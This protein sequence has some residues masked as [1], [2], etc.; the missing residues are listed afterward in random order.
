MY[1]FIDLDTGL[2]AALNKI[3]TWVNSK[4]ASKQDAIND[5]AT[6]RSG[7]ALGATAIQSHQ[8]IKTLNGTSLVGTGNVN[9]PAGVTPHIDE[10]TGNWFI[11]TNDTGIHAQGPKGDTGDV[12]ITDG[13]LDNLNIVNNLEGASG[14]LDSRQGKVIKDLLD[15]FEERLDTIDGASAVSVNATSLVITPLASIDP[16]L[17]VTATDRNILPSLAGGTT[18]TKF[19][20]LGRRLNGDISISAS[21]TTNFSLSQATIP[22]FNGKVNATEITV[23]YHPASGSATNTQHACTITVST[24]GATNVQMSLTGQVVTLSNIVLTPATLQLMSAE[25][26][27]QSSGTIHVAGTAL[28]GDVTLT[29]SDATHLSFSSTATISTIVVTK[30]QAEAGAGYDVL[31]YYDGAATP[32]SATVT[33]TS[34]GADSK[35]VSIAAKVP[36]AK[37][38]GTTFV[39]S[40]LHL[41]FTVLAD[42]ST[43]SVAGSSIPAGTDI[44]IPSTISDL[45]KTCTL[46]DADSEGEGYTYNV[47]KVYGYTGSGSMARGTFTNA[48]SVVIPNSVTSIGQYSFRQNSSIQ[49]LTMST[50]VT[51]IESATFAL[52]TGMTTIT[53]L[54]NVTYAEFNGCSALTSLYMP[55]LS[56]SPTFAFNAC[57]SL[58]KCLI[59]N[60]KIM[61]KMFTG[62]PSGMHLYITSTGAVVGMGAATA[63]WW[64]NAFRSITI[65]GEDKIDIILHVPSTKLAAYQ[66]DTNW[67][68]AKQII[69]E[70]DVD[71]AFHNS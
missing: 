26:N 44:V 24:P 23:T 40:N 65:D 70:T 33:A 39:D 31:I 13:D 7:A 60:A 10:T 22:S 17:V 4:L 36:T 27:Q 69:G 41:K 30:A 2:P 45:G 48:K 12:T 71:A 21:D 47:V 61:N 9:I 53:G 59:K 11:G 54:D 52:C 58:S 15:D 62:C 57:S 55:N 42:T 5:L 19:S 20:V 66:A 51:R 29:L 6:I 14:V 56:S 18:V 3:K 8:S 38:E 1:K 32:V 25:M 49:T 28:E 63:Q 34:T 16:L 43:V 68:D 64:K 50:S 37:A 46:N 35:T 67:K